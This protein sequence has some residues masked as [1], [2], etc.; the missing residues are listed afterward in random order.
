M[1]YQTA[2]KREGVVCGLVEISM[3]IPGRCPIIY[4]SNRIRRGTAAG[5]VRRPL[6]CDVCFVRD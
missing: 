3:E 6:P 5:F 2:W 1:I 4:G